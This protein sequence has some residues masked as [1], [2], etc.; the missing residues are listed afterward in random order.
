[1]NITNT[2]RS[3]LFPAMETVTVLGYCFVIILL[4][5]N[6]RQSHAGPSPVQEATNNS[7]AV[8]SNRPP[9]YREKIQ[10]MDTVQI[11]RELDSADGD[12]IETIIQ[13]ADLERADAVA[14]LW[15]T[16]DVAF[17][18]EKH[19]EYVSGVGTVMVVRASHYKPGEEATIFYRL[20]RRTDKKLVQV[21]LLREMFFFYQERKGEPD[22]S[23]LRK[24]MSRVIDQH[25]ENV[26]VIKE[27]IGHLSDM[28]YRKRL[29]A[30][31]ET[32]TRNTE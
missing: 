18:I 5:A 21:G 14:I 13:F 6:C 3:R 30:I 4:G 29:E 28:D 23:Y 16:L 8:A 17:K 12:G 25:P 22:N 2:H 10:R 7:S 24:V 27:A 26:E 32:L 11:F 20:W 1:M 31:L 15:K 9:V 19:P